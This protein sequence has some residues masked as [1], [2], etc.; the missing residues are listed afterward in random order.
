MHCGGDL[1]RY[2]FYRAL[3]NAGKK[4]HWVFLPNKIVQKVKQSQMIQVGREPTN[5]ERKHENRSCQMESSEN[6]AEGDVQAECETERRVTR[7]R[8]VTLNRP[9]HHMDKNVESNWLLEMI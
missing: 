3:Q 2:L 9:F 8:F 7:V 6:E 4:G 1:T 5:Q